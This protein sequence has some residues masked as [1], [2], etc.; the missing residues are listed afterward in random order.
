MGVVSSLK[1][2]AKAGSGKEARAAGDALKTSLSK[3]MTGAV[4]LKALEL[5]K[6]AASKVY[7]TMDR[8]TD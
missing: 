1:G 5:A 7:E 6:R 4:P 3:T 2:Y 8:L